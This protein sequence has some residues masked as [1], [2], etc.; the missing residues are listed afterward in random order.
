MK[1][2]KPRWFMQSE[3]LNHKYWWQDPK[4]I[5]FCAVTKDLNLDGN[6]DLDSTAS[7]QAHWL[8][9]S[10]LR[11]F[12]IWSC[13]GGTRGWALIG[14]LAGN[15]AA[16]V[17]VIVEYNYWLLTGMNFYEH[18]NISSLRRGELQNNVATVRWN[19][20]NIII[21]KLAAWVQRL[22]RVLFIAE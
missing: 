8:V 6:E 13:G 7:F 3:H 16:Q 15:T 11:V 5:E 18:F 22:H 19:R 1:K 17:T 21:I 10:T 2:T 12:T 14:L 20:E 9:F 4:S